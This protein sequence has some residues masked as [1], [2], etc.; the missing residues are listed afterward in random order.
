LFEELYQLVDEYHLIVKDNGEV[1]L[2]K[3][4]A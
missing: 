4:E 3:K 1:E 2:K